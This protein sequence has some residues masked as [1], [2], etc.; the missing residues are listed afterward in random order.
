MLDS[1]PAMITDTVRTSTVWSNMQTLYSLHW[2]E[3]VLEAERYVVE[4]FVS[5][6]AFRRF[7]DVVLV[8]VILVQRDGV[9]DGVGGRVQHCLPV[10]RQ[11][12]LT[13]GGQQWLTVPQQ[14]V[15]VVEQG[16]PVVEEGVRV[17]YQ[18]LGMEKMRILVV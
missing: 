8:G 14:T 3:F 13:V 17:V 12:V 11:Q 1:I 7:A 4:L 5:V 6:G 15:T 16:L 10:C 2:I 9:G 18:R